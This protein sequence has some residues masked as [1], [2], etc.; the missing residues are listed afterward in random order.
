M[1]AY[2]M[3]RFQRVIGTDGRISG[4]WV[5]L[6]AREGRDELIVKPHNV[7]IYDD[8]RTFGMVL[9]ESDLTAFIRNGNVDIPKHMIGERVLHD[10]EDVWD[11]ML[12]LM[13][14]VSEAFKSATAS[15]QSEE[16]TRG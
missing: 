6:S 2:D 9:G 13:G 4:T 5:A 8:N 11:D 14:L 15:A 1:K 12:A 7:V 3:S 16:H 10:V